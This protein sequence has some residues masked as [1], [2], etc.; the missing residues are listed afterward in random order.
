[1][2]TLDRLVVSR[3]KVSG[4]LR[5]HGRVQAIAQGETGVPLVPYNAWITTLLTREAHD[6]NHEGVAGTL[7]RVRSK[8]WAVQGPRVTRSV[9][10]SCTHC[11]KAKAKMCR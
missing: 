8:A 4:L 3:D 9:I 5:C 1:M 2:T 6:V 11:R 10:D 7:L